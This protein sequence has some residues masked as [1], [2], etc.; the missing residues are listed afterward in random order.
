[1]VEIENKAKNPLD[2]FE[3]TTKEL[4]EAL[5]EWFSEAKDQNPFDLVLWHTHPSGGVGP[6]RT[7]IQQ[8][9]AGVVHLVVALTDDGPVPSFY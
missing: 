4:R 8:K 9:I 1:V 5:E 2:S 7:D 3:F 6:S